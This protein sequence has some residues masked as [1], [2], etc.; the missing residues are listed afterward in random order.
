M[1]VVA[2]VDVV[3]V[4]QIQGRPD[5]AAE[6]APSVMNPNFAVALSR[7]REA[8]RF[9]SN[10]DGFSAFEQTSISAAWMER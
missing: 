7:K 10:V 4:K 1:V 8:E 9:R 6:F 3:S 5:S 2:R